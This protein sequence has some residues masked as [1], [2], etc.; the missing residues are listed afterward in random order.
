MCHSFR[1]MSNGQFSYKSTVS[2]NMKWQD[3]RAGLAS[4][5]KASQKL[6][7]SNFIQGA[8]SQIGYTGSALFLLHSID[9]FQYFVLQLDLQVNHRNGSR[10]A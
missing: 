8:A 3:K 2:E 10:L 5:P 7:R 6:S 9:M 1:E 4:H